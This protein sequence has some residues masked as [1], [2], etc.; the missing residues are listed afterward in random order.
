[1]GRAV[2]RAGNGAA[3]HADSVTGQSHPVTHTRTLKAPALRDGVAAIA[4]VSHHD[5]T[6]SV[7]DFTPKVGALVGGFFLDTEVAHWCR[8][9][10]QTGG[11]IRPARVLPAFGQIRLLMVRIDSDG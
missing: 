9:A 2:P 1:M 8:V 3:V 6:F 4:R 10:M 11:H 5:A 7:V